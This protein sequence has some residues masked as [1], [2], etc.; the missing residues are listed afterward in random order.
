MIVNNTNITLIDLLLFIIF[1]S[2]LNYFIYYYFIKKEPFTV[3]DA[4]NINNYEQVK[5]D[6]INNKTD[7][8]DIY[9]PDQKDIIDYAPTTKI[10]NVNTSDYEKCKKIFKPK[11][12]IQIFGN[13]EF[14]NYHKPPK[15]QILNNYQIKGYNYAEYDSAM[16][17]NK[18]DKRILTI[19]TKGL[20]DTTKMI[21]YN[22]GY[23]FY[24]SPAY[25][26]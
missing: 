12:N 9:N 13:N 17:P 4:N 20:D 15:H 3:N 23:A 22:S 21:P 18:I 26:K 2:I 8:F 10:L 1:V 24:D 6:I 19:N 25:T 14:V 7:K 11:N 16:Q 5:Q